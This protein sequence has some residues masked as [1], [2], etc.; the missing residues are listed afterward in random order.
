MFAEHEVTYADCAFHPLDSGQ[1]A[2]G[3]QLSTRSRIDDMHVRYEPYT[4]ISG[5]YDVAAGS[6]RQSVTVVAAD[7]IRTAR[8]GTKLI[9]IR[10]SSGSF[11]RKR[12]LESE[13]G[14]LA[15]GRGIEVKLSHKPRLYRVVPDL[16]RLANDAI[17]RGSTVIAAV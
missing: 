9:I 13:I 1:V 4:V 17:V 5:L 7:I 14:L 10:S 8:P 16:L 3:V 2:V 6:I 15:A 12:S 11:M